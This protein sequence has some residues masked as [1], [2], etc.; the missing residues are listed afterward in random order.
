M[1]CKTL[2]EKMIKSLK[3]IQEVLTTGKHILCTAARKIDIK[4]MSVLS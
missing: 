3:D 4:M 1:M 2:L